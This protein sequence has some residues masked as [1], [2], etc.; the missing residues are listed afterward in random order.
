ML[1]EKENTIQLL[2]KNLNT[3]STQLIQASDPSEFEKEKES[4]NGKL[5]DCQAQLLK[6]I[7]KQNQWQRDMSLMVESEKD[8]KGKSDELEKRLQEKEREL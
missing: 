5:T 6:F 4:L 7:E 1:N 3:P 2:K 8:L